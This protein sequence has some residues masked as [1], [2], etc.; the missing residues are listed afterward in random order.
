MRTTAVARFLPLSLL[1]LVL[2]V[3]GC[4]SKSGSTPESSNS[5]SPSNPSSPN[6]ASNSVP[7]AAPVAPAPV[8]APPPPPIV[9]PA[10][11]TIHVTLDQTVNSATA[12][13]GDP[14]AASLAVPV[15]SGSLVVL[16]VGTKVGGTVVTA[17]SAGKFKG[18]ALLQLVI[19]SVRINGT[20]YPMQTNEIE[21]VGKSRGKRTAVGAGGGAAFGAILGA[22]AGGGKGAAIGALAGGGAGTA[23]AAFT[24]KKDIVLPAETRLHFRLA[25]PLSVPAPDASAP[26]APPATN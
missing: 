25:Q 18:Q 22:V 26:A 16:P 15:T 11:T 21:D 5:A 19:D 17:Q 23:G 3:S 1:S 14:F 12:N 7:G 6:S 24:G 20:R 10:G 2:A 13:N 8:P 9:I 4:G